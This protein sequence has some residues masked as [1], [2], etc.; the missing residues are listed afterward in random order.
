MRETNNLRIIKLILV[1]LNDAFSLSL[2]QIYR[3]LTNVKCRFIKDYREFEY[4]GVSSEMGVPFL[5]YL[6]DF[7][8]DKLY[9]VCDCLIMTHI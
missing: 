4:V 7:Q 3:E 9:F 1:S 8:I 6:F 2:S 5:F